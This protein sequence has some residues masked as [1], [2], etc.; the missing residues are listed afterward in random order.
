V[1]TS[2]PRTW[3][4]GPALILSVGAVALMLVTALVER[5]VA[6]SGPPRR[7]WCKAE[8]ESEWLRFDA[9]SVARRPGGEPFPEVQ[10][11]TG[12]LVGGSSRITGYVLLHEEASR[13]R[14]ALASHGLIDRPDVVDFSYDMKFDERVVVDGISW[15][16]FDLRESESR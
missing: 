5:Q 13:L 4:L 6:T 8:V 11:G 14:C 10:H 15:L 3:R 9:T 16:P 7:V 12:A 2:T 1:D